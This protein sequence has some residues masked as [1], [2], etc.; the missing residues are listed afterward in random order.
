M[1]AK[2]AGVLLAAVLVL[3][4]CSEDD[5][6][7]REPAPTP[8]ASAS[9]STTPAVDVCAVLDP[10]ERAALVGLANPRRLQ[11][12]A[13]LSG[14]GCYWTDPDNPSITLTVVA[15]ST[16]EWLTGLPSALSALEQDDDLSKDERQRVD[17]MRQEVD[18]LSEDDVDHAC[19]LFASLAEIYGQPAGSATTVQGTRS[20][21]GLSAQHCEG[22]QFTSVVGN[23]PDLRLSRHLVDD[24][25][26]AV[27]KVAGAR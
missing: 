4:G 23:A 16:R 9:E 17:R 15:M 12:P 26:D 24:Y 3:A 5:P 7:S 27:E 19:D 8:S 20:G 1:S 14:E 6:G 10:Q 2:A 25:R 21:Q 13:R 18:S 11:G 22:D